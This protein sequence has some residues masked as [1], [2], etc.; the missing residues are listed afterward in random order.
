MAEELSSE[1]E[2]TPITTK[3]ELHVKTDGTDNNT[4]SEKLIVGDKT[5]SFDTALSNQVVF[6]S[7][8]SSM[9]MM[10]SSWFDNCLV[11]KVETGHPGFLLKVDR[12]IL[13]LKL[14]DEFEAV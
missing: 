10:D 3:F 12:S 11:R 7:T 1:A 5:F 8:Y 6:N 9:V 13:F 14:A 2:T 4:E